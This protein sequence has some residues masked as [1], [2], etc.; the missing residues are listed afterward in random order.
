[1]QYFQ[2]L[3]RSAHICHLKFIRDSILKVKSNRLIEKLRA[4]HF[5]PQTGGTFNKACEFYSPHNTVFIHLCPESLFPPSPFNQTIWKEFMIIAGMKHNV[6]REKFIQFARQIEKNGL[7]EKS[8]SQSKELVRHLFSRKDLTDDVDFLSQINKIK[9]IMP[10]VV[11]DNFHT[12]YPQFNSNKL[13]PFIGSVREENFVLA[14][15]TDNI[16]PSYAVPNKSVIQ[17]RLQIKINPTT[18]NLRIHIGNVC[19]S[20]Q[21]GKLKTESKFINDVMTKIYRYLRD[22]LENEPNQLKHLL[23][24]IPVVHIIERHLF[25]KAT[26]VVLKEPQTIEIEPYLMLASEKYEEFFEIF[27]R[28][29]ATNQITLDHYLRVLSSVK[30]E[31]GDLQLHAN[32]LQQTEKAVRGMLTL[33]QNKSSQDEETMTIPICY[34]LSEEKTLHPSSDLIFSDRHDWKKRLKQHHEIK[35]LANID[36]FKEAGLDVDKCLSMLPDRCKLQKL[37]SVVEEELLTSE[38]KVYWEVTN[39]LEVFL[40]SNIFVHCMIRLIKSEQKI[41]NLDNEVIDSITASLKSIKVVALQLVR[42]IL[43]HKN[44]RIESSVEDKACY[45]LRAKNIFFITMSDLDITKWIAR[46]LHHIA[47]VV[48]TLCEEKA[49]MKHIQAVISNHNST[50]EEMSNLLDDLDVRPVDYTP[51]ENSWAPSPGTPVPRECLQFLVQELVQ[52]SS[53][54]YAVFEV[55]DNLHDDVEDEQGKAA[56]YI[57]VKIVDCLSTDQD[58]FPLYKVDI[59]DGQT[60]DV[61]S[62]RLYVIVRPRSTDGGSTAGNH[63]ETC[64]Y[65]GEKRVYTEK[66]KAAI[67]QE[68]EEVLVDAWHISSD[69]FRRVYKRLLLRW[70]PDKN[71]NSKLCT[72][73]TKHI[74]NFAKRLQSGN[75]DSTKIPSYRERYGNRYNREGYRRQW[76]DYVH[77]ANNTSGNASQHGA[78]PTFD[79]EEF[80]E[81]VRRQ[82]RYAS[83]NNWQDDNQ[84]NPQPEMAKV[85]ITQA[86][87]DLTAAKLLMTVATSESYNWV[88]VTSHQVWFFFYL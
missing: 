65:T 70:H 42:T 64:L 13:V 46:Y 60:M 76:D 78:Y 25:L 73:I 14:W 84:P 85:W 22:I 18:D 31:A 34:L 88:C 33:L 59:G 69:D 1:M 23:A 24:D 52:F 55:F 49:Q 37:S 87:N 27:R 29:G 9:F 41:V 21:N 30:A 12:I 5:I 61:R 75:I 77:R 6:C 68:I 15:T 38:N 74:I 17:E 83:W 36:H 50:A 54:D 66:D 63:L 7:S 35:F 19:G 45:H 20:L 39:A 79:P 53:G 56:V 4:L 10:F 57:Y 26:N 58:Q 40:K 62:L 11:Q 81:R 86:K 51:V 3:P 2:H 82:T 48:Y 72:E 44:V 43:V 67:V 8:K 47:S 16:L 71:Q 28:L 80:A 32:E